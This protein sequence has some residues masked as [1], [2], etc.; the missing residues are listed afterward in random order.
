M[1]DASNATIGGK[2]NGMFG[3]LVV[4]NLPSRTDRRAEFGQQLG[5]IG[6][7]YESA[8][9]QLF[10]AVRPD[11]AGGFPTIGTRGCFLSHL[12]VLRGAVRR[13][14]DGIL[15]C[16]D[17]LNFDTG[18]GGRID[19]LSEQL[20]HASWDIFYGGYETEPAGQAVDPQGDLVVVT[21]EEPIICAHF[22]AFRHSAMVKLVPYLEAILSRPAGDPAGG[23]MHVDGAYNWFRRAHPELVTLAARTPLGYQR[24]SQTNIHQLG[25]HDRTPVVRQGVSMLRRIRNR[26]RG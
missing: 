19:Y 25:W 26:L 11:D 9:V 10:P 16:E 21:P 23:P 7:S 1:L 14:A 2:M 4:I 15:V 22:I 12:S 13:G 18:L 8:G 24:A 5:R 3:D 17:D 6:L 20:H